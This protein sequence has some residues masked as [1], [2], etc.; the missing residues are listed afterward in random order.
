MPPSLLELWLCQLEQNHDTI[1][2]DKCAGEYIRE[3]GD[4]TDMS[5]AIGLIGKDGI[6]LATDSRTTNQE[7]GMTY[8]Q[9]N[10]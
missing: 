1:T 9:D 3:R 4:G 5:I 2:H 7:G 10:A 6:V 8:H